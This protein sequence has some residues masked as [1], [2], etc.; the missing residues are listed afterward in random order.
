MPSDGVIRQLD[1]LIET[2]KNEMETSRTPENLAITSVLLAVRGAIEAN[3]IE[4]LCNVTRSFAIVMRN[5][6]LQRTG[7]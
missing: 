6:L 3:Q 1:Q 7:N 2:A 4:D 5:A